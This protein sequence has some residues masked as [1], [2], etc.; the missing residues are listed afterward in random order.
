MKT[1]CFQPIKYETNLQLLNLGSNT[2]DNILCVLFLSHFLKNERKPSKTPHTSLLMLNASNDNS[3]VTTKSSS[4]KSYK[5]SE[6]PNFSLS[7][8]LIVI[9][10]FKAL[11]SNKC[12]RDWFNTQALTIEDKTSIII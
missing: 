12:P 9:I 4:I 8:K 1:T 10:T 2:S 6:I 7:F 11:E 5:L 3:W